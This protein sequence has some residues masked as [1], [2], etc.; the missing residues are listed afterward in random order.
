VI[1]FHGGPDKV[2][3]ARGVRKVLAPGGKFAVVN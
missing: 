1:P 3:L 2:G